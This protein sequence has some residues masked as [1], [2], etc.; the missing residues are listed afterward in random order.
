MKGLWMKGKAICVL[1]RALNRL[2]K[3]MVVA[4]VIC[5]CAVNE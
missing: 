1:E 3:G 4:A 2:D 5:H